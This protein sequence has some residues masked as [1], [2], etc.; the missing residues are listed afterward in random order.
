MSNELNAGILSN[1]GQFLL[2]YISQLGLSKT[3]FSWTWKKSNI[4]PVTF[5][6]GCVHTV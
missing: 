5:R 6:K 3:V 2:I 4:L 1:V